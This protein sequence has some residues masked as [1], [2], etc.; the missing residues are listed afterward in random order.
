MSKK[1]TKK[2]V[3]VKK[4]KKKFQETLGFRIFI[5]FLA[6]L[7]VVGPIAGLIMQFKNK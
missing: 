3:E 1:N 5:L 2:T 6:V 4:P 7:F